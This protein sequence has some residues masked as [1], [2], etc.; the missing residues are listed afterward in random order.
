MDGTTGEDQYLVENYVVFLFKSGWEFPARNFLCS[1]G[2]LSWNLWRFWDILLLVDGFV[3]EFVAFPGHFVTSGRF[4][5]G[6]VAEMRIFG[7]CVGK[8]GILL[9]LHPVNF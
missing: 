6:F 1:C 5:P 7:C 4:C 8:W 3:P 2:V 9:S